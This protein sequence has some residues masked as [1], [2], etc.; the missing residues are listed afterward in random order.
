MIGRKGRTE[1]GDPEVAD[2]WGNLGSAMALSS[3]TL[4]QLSQPQ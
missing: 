4:G 3:V 1:E 2:L